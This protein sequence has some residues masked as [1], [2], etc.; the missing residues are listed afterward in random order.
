M[1][2][3]QTVVVGAGVVGL[4]TARELARSGREV[5]VLEAEDAFGTQTSAR[6][7]EVI[8]AGLYYPAGSLK[9]MLCVAGK[10][11][12]YAY[13]AERGVAHRRVGKLVVATSDA[14]RGPLQALARA[15]EGNGVALQ[16]L[17][18]VA[19]ARL[20]PAV[21]AVAGL[22]SE[23]SGIVDSHGLMLALLGDAQAAGATLVLRAPVTGGAVTRDGLV[24]DVGGAEP[25]ALGAREVVNAAGLRAQRVAAA[26]DALPRRHVPSAHFAKGHYFGLAGPS[27]FRHLVYPMPVP[28]GL[29]IHVTL[30]L[31]G[32]CRFG[33]DVTR[34]LDEP[35]YGFEEGL[36]PA[37]A[38]AI[39]R[40]WPDL[41]DG[42][43]QPDYTG[44]R[45]K[46]VGPGEPAAD[47]VVDGPAQHG[48]PGLVNLFGIESPGLTACLAIAGL[49]RERLDAAA[50]G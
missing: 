11:M 3:V 21:R 43:L 26:I 10:A 46:V 45:P 34:W 44:V 5:L 20:E 37:F 4:A 40:Y 18:A 42:A 27:P 23:S 19:V 50:G 25:M 28:G 39:R 49:V 36:A 16:P 15:A 13:C 31:A 47:F 9:A 32:R 22:W 24:L 29:G 30:D 38:A 2:S 1:E 7:S 8:H 35:E 14:E 33:P 12:L 17:D 41:P 48:V 6:N